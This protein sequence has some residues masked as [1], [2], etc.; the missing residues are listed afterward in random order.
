[1]LRDVVIV[2]A[3]PRTS[4]EGNEDSGNE[5]VLPWEKSIHGFPF[6]SGSPL[7]SLSGR[8]G[9]AITVLE[10]AALIS[11]SLKENSLRRKWVSRKV[12]R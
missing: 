5:I 12:L 8:W 3:R 9:S 11:F 6:L 4:R 7:D 2:R 1:M 10:A